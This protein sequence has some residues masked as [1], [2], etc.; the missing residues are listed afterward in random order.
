VGGTITTYT[1]IDGGPTG[2]GSLNASPAGS[3]TP[4]FPK[5]FFRGPTQI[6]DVDFRITRDFKLY[7]E[8]YKL[9]I[10][11]EA[12]NL[13]NH[14]MV[15]TVNFQAYGE[16]NPVGSS[17]TNPTL[18]PQTGSFLTTSATSNSLNTARQLQIS[19]KFFF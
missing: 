14:A 6:R 16:T 2:G 3:R 11:G 1:G 13:F 10:V 8:R 7:H 17:T 4:L 5:N 15:T 9:Q 12:F 18:T 19:G